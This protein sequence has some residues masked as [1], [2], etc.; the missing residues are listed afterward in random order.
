MRTRHA[1]AVVLS[2][3][4][5]AGCTSLGSLTNK[6]ETAVTARPQASEEAA[7]P[8]ILRVGDKTVVGNVDPQPV[9]A[10]GLVWKLNG[11][12]SA[13][14]GEWR[15]MLERDLR[16][17]KL[18]NTRQF[19]DDPNKSTSLVLV[20]AVIPP[21][22]RRGDMIDIDVTLPRG[23]QT[24][25][26]KGGALLECDLAVSEESG[27]VR[28]AMA[29]SGAPVG[30]NPASGNTLLIGKTLVRAEGPLVVGSTE[31]TAKAKAKIEGE[32]EPEDRFTA[33]R[34][35]GGGRVLEDRPYYLVINDK[36][37]R[38]AMETAERLNATFQPHGDTRAR[39]ANAVNGTV[40]SVNVPAAY[41][42]NH[43]RFLTVARQ[44]PLAPVSPD[45]AYRKQLEQE[46]LEPSTAITAAIKLEALGGESQQPLRVAM[47]SPSPWVRFAA[48]EALAYLG[49]TAAAAELA[50]LAELHPALRTHC[51]VALASL[52]DGVST[53]R[54]VEL[55]AHPD[56]QLRYGA[57][58]ALRTANEHHAAL[59][60]KHVKKTFWVHQVASDSTPLVHLA[61]AKRA[62]IV[63]FGKQSDLL[64]P[65]SFAIGKEYT[66]TAKIGDSQATL[67]KIVNGTD[68]AT[69]VSTKCGLSIAGMLSGLGEM[70]AGYS[71]AVELI[72][73]ADAAK[74]VAA[75]IAVDANP[76]GIALIQLA[77]LARSEANLDRANLEVERVCRGD[78]TPA[79]YD[80]PNFDEPKPLAPLEAADLSRNPGR[81]FG[82]K[83]HP[84][85][86]AEEPV[87]KPAEKP[88][89]GAL[90]R[91][92]GKLF[93]K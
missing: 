34:I 49:N 85:D 86:D 83:K 16:K 27:A 65:F 11:T 74:L 58:T 71:E 40:V 67:T 35:W 44:V 13:A 78:V 25:S 3:G 64:P 14:G 54:L 76:Q 52:D 41:R 26:L 6:P 80:L 1:F 19:L 91:Q 10:V 33:G 31:T 84:M 4:S 62:E 82:G 69:D 17:K 30:A 48:A 23:S 75:N 72:R 29:K 73:R 63:L 53:D 24:T 12:G 43:T 47:Q 50:K 68:G 57:F 28:E 15:A 88:V 92:P 79:S 2:L 20:S 32:A 59:N 39:M 7:A 21:G 56:T 89:E 46:L 81:I 38:L 8:A 22:A 9:S 51:L 77:T 55:M 36:N 37:A 66:V 60:G 45:S 18:P 61:S 42:M 90:S 5:L 93:G 70:G 87:A